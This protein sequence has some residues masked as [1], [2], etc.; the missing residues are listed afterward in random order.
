MRVLV[1]ELHLLLSSSVNQPRQHSFK[2]DTSSI[3]HKKEQVTCHRHIYST[4]VS[5]QNCCKK[6]I[7]IFRDC[8]SYSP[9]SN[10]HISSHTHTDFIHTTIAFHPYSLTLSLSL[11]RSSD[12]FFSQKPTTHIHLL[13]TRRSLS[14]RRSRVEN[15]KTSNKIKRISKNFIYSHQSFHFQSLY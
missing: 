3:Y 9:T 12:S 7:Y 8:H 11:L 2:L 1:R 5:R 4:L 13:S 10:L 15:I 14:S 6:L